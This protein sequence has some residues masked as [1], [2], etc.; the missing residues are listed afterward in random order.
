M[1]SALNVRLNFPALVGVPLKVAVLVLNVIPVGR[2]P[3]TDHVTSALF[4]S[5]ICVAVYASFNIPY[6]RLDVA[7]TGV[8]A[9]IT[10]KVNSFVS[11]P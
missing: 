6:G 2:V 3:L 5:F 1:L 4:E 11:V 9:A 10:V 8:S 7:I